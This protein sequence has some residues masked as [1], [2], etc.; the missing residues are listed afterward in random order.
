[1]ASPYSPSAVIQRSL[2]AHASI[3]ALTIDRS[4]NKLAQ[5][6]DFTWFF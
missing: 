4:V 6:L 2:V 3:A 5:S 1:V